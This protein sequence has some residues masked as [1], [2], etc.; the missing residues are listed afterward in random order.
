MIE[1]FTALLLAHVLADFV[2]QTRWMVANKRRAAGL[3]L[4]GTVVLMDALPP[5][6][7]GR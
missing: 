3:A 1:T 6:E 4:H 7:T 2:L 5:I